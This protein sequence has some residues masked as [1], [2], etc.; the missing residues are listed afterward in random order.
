VSQ[1]EKLLAEIRRGNRSVRFS[2]LKKALMSSG[3]ELVNIR[4]S[5]H[6]FKKE[7]KTLVLVKPHGNQKTFHPKTLKDIAKLF[8]P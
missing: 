2:E 6:T 3:W 8:D 1:W 4:G 7:G 5:H